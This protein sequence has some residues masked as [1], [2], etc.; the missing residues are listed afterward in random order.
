MHIRVQRVPSDLHV[1]EERYHD[2]CRKLFMNPN[3]VRATQNPKEEILNGDAAAA[4]LVKMIKLANKRIWT[5]AELHSLYLDKGGKDLNRTRL[6]NKVTEYMENE[7]VA[8][9]SR[10]VASIIMMNE[11]AS[12]SLKELMKKIMILT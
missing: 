2:S 5:S 10:G 1:A 8:L 6:L 3:N 7:V 12:Q 4:S 11:K 9:L